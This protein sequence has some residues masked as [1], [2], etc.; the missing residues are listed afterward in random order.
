MYKLN[1]LYKFDTVFAFGGNVLSRLDFPSQ[2]FY[3]NIS[4]DF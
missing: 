4:F 2:T 3:F 1:T